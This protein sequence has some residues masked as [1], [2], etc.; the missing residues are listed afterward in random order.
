MLPFSVLT[1]CFIATS[2]S[3][4]NLS[5]MPVERQVDDML[6]TAPSSRLKLFHRRDHRPFHDLSTQ[7][8]LN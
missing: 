8:K 6:K 7:E 1:E 4:G 5:G 3:C 2:Y